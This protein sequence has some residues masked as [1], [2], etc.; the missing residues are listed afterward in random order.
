[1]RNRVQGGLA[2]LLGV[3]VA[4][5]IGA[6][7][8]DDGSSGAGTE[9]TWFV[10]VQRGGSFEASAERCTEESNGRYSIKVELLPLQADAQREQLVRRLGAEDS[11]ID[12][13]GMDVIWTAEFANAGWVREWTGPLAER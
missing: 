13:I 7:T 9:L 11:S 2:A 5:A 1:M 10:A 3:A 6:C 12:I 8:G 4:V